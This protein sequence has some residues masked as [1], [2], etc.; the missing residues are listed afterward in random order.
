MCPH[1]SCI[2]ILDFGSQYTQLIARKI[3]AS[4]VYSEILPY[5][6]TI[7]KIRE[8]SPVGLVF[9]GGPREAYGVD[10][11]KPSEEIWELCIPIIGICY[12]MKLM[13]Q[14]FGG[15]VEKGE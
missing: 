4:N 10:A 7:S 8:L 3:R 13:A 11:P 12:G 15:L 5:F 6:T 1:K 2:A 9:S 14:K